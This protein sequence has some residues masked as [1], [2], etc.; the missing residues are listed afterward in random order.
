MKHEKAPETFEMENGKKNVQIKMHFMF[1]IFQRYRLP[2][3]TFHKL[4]LGFNYWYR[5]TESNITVLI[6]GFRQKHD[7][8]QVALKAEIVFK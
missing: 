8:F 4:V 6:A 3:T 5:V 1:I 2:E 7:S